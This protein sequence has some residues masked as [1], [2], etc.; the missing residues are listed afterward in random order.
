VLPDQHHAQAHGI[1]SADHSGFP[2]GTTTFLRA[3][4]TFA[5]PAGSTPEIT[6]VS[7]A[8]GAA[9]ADITYQRLTANSADVTTTALSAAV[10]ALTGVGAGV[11]RIVAHL[12]YQT[13][14]TTTGIAFGLNH[15]GAG[16]VVAH[17]LWLH[18]TTGGA[19]ATGVGDN[20]AATVAGQ[21]AEGK[22]E[23]VLNAVIGS[24]SA[25]VAVA[26]ASVFA[27]LHALVVVTVSGTLEL[28]LASEIAG[29][30][31]RLMANSVLELVRVA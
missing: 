17:A 10:M 27:T 2:G 31:V 5:A 21:L 8:S 25:G 16:S 4:G 23:A 7:G 15:T 6:R 28:K 20:D 19:A 24:A 30:A 9:G 14:A 26:N 29:S 13:A 12:I 22:S 11:W 3:D 1:T 18:V